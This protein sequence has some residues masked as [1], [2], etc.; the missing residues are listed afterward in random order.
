MLIAED[1]KGTPR[2]RLA[3]LG[4]GAVTERQR[5]AEAGITAMGL[6]TETQLNTSS[7][8]GTRLN[9]APEIL[10]GKPATL[11]ADIFTLGVMLYQ[12]VAGDFSRALAPGPDS[13]LRRVTLKDI[14]AS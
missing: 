10:E 1:D 11:Q 7:G 4:I 3:N 13:G 14:T 12:M 9:L 8:S 5:L 2:I 6:T